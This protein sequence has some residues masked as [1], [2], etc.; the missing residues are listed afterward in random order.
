MRIDC[1]ALGCDG[2]AKELCHGCHMVYCRD[3]VDPKT[4]ECGEVWVDG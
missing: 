2:E 4:H 3:C 1:E